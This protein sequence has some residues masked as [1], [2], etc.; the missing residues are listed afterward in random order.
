MKILVVGAGF[1]GS[2]CSR[3]LAEAGHEVTLIEKRDHVGGN[4]YDEYDT[5]GI[6]VH[7]YG[8]H[9]FHTNSERV[10]SW[11]S[12]FTEWREYEHR[13]LA[14][15]DDYYV[16]FP[17]NRTTINTIYGLS[18]TEAQ[19][20]EYIDKVRIAIQPISTSEDV[21]LN[22]VGRDL[23]DK[24]FRNYTKKQWGLNLSQLSAEVAARVPI[25]YNDD[26][27]YFTDKFQAMPKFGY[28]KLFEN[29]LDHPKICLRL[30]VNFHDDKIA[31]RVRF[32]HIVYTGLIDEFYG[33]CLGS[34]PYRSLKFRHVQLP[35]FER[36]QKVGTVNYPNTGNYT[37]ITEFKHLTGQKHKYTSIVLEYPRV[38]GEP[39]YPVPRPENEALYQEYKKL[40]KKEKH[41][42]FVGR[43]AQ[44]R[45]YNMDQVIAAALTVCQPLIR[46]DGGQGISREGPESP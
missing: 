37:R 10:F 28:T 31:Y 14:F 38:L 7:R 4:A 27:R 34:L 6:L 23:C 36:F 17:I 40:S 33:F 44:Y 24:F 11:V 30:G 43:L 41:V 16:P 1:A 42:T 20:T 29:I 18:L 46:V 32:D 35:H 12:R 45:Y 13:V 21:I 8:P 25:R 39:Y 19:I 3:E 26:D 15:V 2:V 22:S 9:I 5:S